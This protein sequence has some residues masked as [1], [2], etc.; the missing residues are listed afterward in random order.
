MK[1]QLTGCHFKGAAKV[2]LASKTALPEFTD[3]SFQ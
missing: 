3:G 2:Q 1:D